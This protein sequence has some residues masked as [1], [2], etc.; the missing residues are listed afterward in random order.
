MPTFPIGF[1]DYW[2]QTVRE[3]IGRGLLR[4]CNPSSFIPQRPMPDGGPAS[5]LDIIK[6]VALRLY[7]H[8]QMSFPKTGGNGTDNGTDA[9]FC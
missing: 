1:G 3:L 9:T 4:I 5:T 7:L 2:L 8:D 6:L